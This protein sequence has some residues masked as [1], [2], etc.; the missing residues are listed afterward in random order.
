MCLTI[1]ADDLNVVHWWV[2]VVYGVHNDLK[3]RTG[4]TISTGKGSVTS[5]SRKQKIN[6][7]S[8]T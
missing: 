7:T 5:K 1:N 8:S 4:A 6:T 2:D 3:G